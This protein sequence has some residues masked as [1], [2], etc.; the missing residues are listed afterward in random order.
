MTG[1]FSQFQTSPAPPTPASIPR[2]PTSPGGF[3]SQKTSTSDPQQRSQSERE[4]SLSVSP[5]T[6]LPSQPGGDISLLQQ[7]ENIYI[8]T[9][10]RKM[11][12]RNA[13]GEDPKNTQSAVKPEV[14]GDTRLPSTSNSSPQQPAR[15]RIRY[16]EPPIWA[17]SVKG[18]KSIYAPAVGRPNANINGKQQVAIVAAHAP[19]HAVV[20]VETNGHRLSPSVVANDDI[21]HPSKLL[22]PW[23]WSIIKTRPP[24]PTIK[25]VADWLFINAVSRSDFGELN[26]RGVEIEIEAKLGQLIDRETN[27]RFEMPVRTEC[28]LINSGVAFRSSMTEVRGSFKFSSSY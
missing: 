21:F 17:Q 28:V 11:G 4:R 8:N 1:P 26:S 18:R 24:D 3:D 20:N 23:E 10:K 2:L 19:P 13:P 15:K 22:G 16:N 5:K 14:N 7:P 12:D 25:A 27:H 9:A 6:R